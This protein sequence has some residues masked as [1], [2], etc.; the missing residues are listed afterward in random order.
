MLWGYENFRLAI[1]LQKEL[2]V[3]FPKLVFRNSIQTNGALLNDQWIE[4]LHD[5]N[6][7]IG[8]SIDG[9][10]EINFH[11]GPFN[12]KV[13]IENIHKLTQKKCKFG[14]L[15]VITNEHAGWDF[16]ENEK[17]VSCGDD[18]SATTMVTTTF[19]VVDTDNIPIPGATIYFGSTSTYYKCDNNGQLQLTTSVG[20]WKTFWASADGYNDSD[21]FRDKPIS[22]YNKEY[23]ITLSLIPV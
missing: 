12:D 4:F 8:I 11:K 3:K 13:V 16:V 17:G 19:R 7:D 1:E 14:V 22:K 10:S 21:K 15:S 6:F 5:N 20:T 18:I 23:T 2:A 9:P